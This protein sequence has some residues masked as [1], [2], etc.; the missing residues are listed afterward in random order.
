[1]EKENI[2]TNKEQ[3]FTIYRTEEVNDAEEELELAS[4]YQFDGGDCSL[5]ELAFAIAQFLKQLDKDDTLAVNKDGGK[6]FLQ[7]INTYYNQSDEQ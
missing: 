2:I 1:M 4:G 6:Y 5:P 7:L 3:I